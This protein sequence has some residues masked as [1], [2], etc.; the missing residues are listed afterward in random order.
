MPEDKRV[1]IDISSMRADLED[2]SNSH[3]RWVPGPQMVADD[4]TKMS[5]NGV[6][7]DVMIEGRWSL[8]EEA[9]VREHRRAARERLLASKS[10]KLKAEMQVKSASE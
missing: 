10:E 4:L 8:C 7:L 5:G 1:A 2:S 9:A 6:L 3:L